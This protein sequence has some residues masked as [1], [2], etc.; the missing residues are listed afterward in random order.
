MSRRYDEIGIQ[1]AARRRADPRIA[2]RIHAALGDARSVVNVGA[3]TGNYEPTDREVVAIE[4]SAVMAAQRPPHL[5]RAV[6]AS[7]ERLPLDDDSVDA[8]MAVLTIHHWSDP[9]AGVREMQR[10]AR[11]RIVIVGVDTAV[12]SRLWL[13]AEYMP[14]VAER[15][16]REFPAIDTVLGWLGP[17]AR[18]EVLPVPRDCTDGFL[19]S[20]WGTPERVLDPRARA[21]TSA[22]ARLT[23]EREAEIVEQVRRDLDSGDWDARHG[24]LRELD[25]Y[26]AGLRLVAT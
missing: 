12:F 13:A 8:A 10:V 22:F 7:A 16:A 9:A 6:P 25:E 26:D 23:P 15:D 5:T 14:D 24:H 21:A 20:F 18:V 11:E 4:P 17:A 2:A 19:L 3:G 1:Y